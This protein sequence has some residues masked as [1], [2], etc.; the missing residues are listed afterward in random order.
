M[1]RTTDAEEAKADE[2][3]TAPR[4]H[5]DAPRTA[6]GT[7]GA[8]AAGP[9]P[10]APGPGGDPA[11]RSAGEPSGAPNAETG[12]PHHLKEWRGKFLIGSGTVLTGAIGIWIAGWLGFF[13]GPEITAPPSTP[14]SVEPIIDPGHL[15]G[16]QDVSTMASGHRFFAVPNFYYFQAC[17][18]PCWLPLYQQPTEQ[19]AFVT[20]GWPCEYYGPNYSS[21]P[22]CTQPPSRRTAG[23]MADPAVKDS[24]DR[25]LVI[26]QT[27]RLNAGS[28]TPTIHNQVGQGS[29]IWDMVAVP[30]AYISSDSPAAGR[31][32]QVS[33]MPGFYQAYAPD[34]WL[35][36]T[37]WHDIPC[38]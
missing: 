34:I 4:Q 35:G 11:G 33:G 28:A 24:G 26:C 3:G 17:G 30:K 12:R 18:R 25:L 14:P 21:A 22:S 36:N 32:A 1:A 37:G 16:R 20:D 27:T 5:Q 13:A 29:D 9:K 7:E 10:P 23:E 15:P 8:D 6:E 19:S 38:G 31:I 2:N